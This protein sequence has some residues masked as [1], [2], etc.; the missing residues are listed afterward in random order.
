[1]DEYL[2]SRD[3]PNVVNVSPL[4]KGRRVLSFLADFFLI[5][6]MSLVFFNAVAYP[7]AGAITDYNGH[8]TSYKTSVKKRDGVLYGSKI[9]FYDANKSTPEA[10]ALTANMSYTCDKF[11]EYYV[12]GGADKA[13]YEIFFTYYETLRSPNIP[14]TEFYGSIAS[15]GDYFLL[16]G[17]NIALKDKYKGEWAPLFNPGDEMS[18]QGK[19]DYNN[20]RNSFF[21][22]GYSAMIKDI[23][24]R[25][26]VY[27]GVS[28]ITE[29]NTVLAYGR[30]IDTLVI[31][32]ALISYFL[33]VIIDAL[34]LPVIS[35]RRKTLAMLF[36]KQSRVEISNFNIFS[37]AKVPL[38]FV[39]MTALCFGCVIFIPW[40][41]ISFN[42]L[43]SIPM[44]L[45]LSLVGLTLSIISLAFLLIDGYGRSLSDKLTFSFLVDE[46][47]YGE[48]CRAKGYEI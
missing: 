20:F 19:T 45:P 46:D 15:F 47:G 44:L 18:E 5:V 39:Y 31:T 41:V 21:L 12:K 40:G 1:M 16:E 4:S 42:E 14:L 17:S 35:S 33:A 11:V 8:Y 22:Q 38:S 26:L 24:E 7:I 25:D 30:Y 37:K 9:L 32:C 34:L 23:L 2:D 6:I 28:Y 36:L 27:E 43:F 48:I 13:Q 10:S 29:Q 3:E